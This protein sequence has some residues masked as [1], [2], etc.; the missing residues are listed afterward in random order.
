MTLGWVGFGGGVELDVAMARV[1]F[2]S[3]QAFKKSR[4][5]RG[6]ARR[7]KENRVQLL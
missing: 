2:A 4:P 3:T 6:R 7:R 1:F 5:M